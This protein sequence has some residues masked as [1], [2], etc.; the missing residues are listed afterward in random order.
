MDLDGS[1][2]RKSNCEKAKSK[3]TASVKRKNRKRTA[4]GKRQTA[5]RGDQQP[6]LSS[7]ASSAIP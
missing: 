6:T 7:P 3:K 4:N 2:G 5:I 1:T